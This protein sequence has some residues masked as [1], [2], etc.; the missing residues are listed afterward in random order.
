MGL[1]ID[2]KRANKPKPRGENCAPK[3]R[4]N[5]TVSSYL[6]MRVLGAIESAPGNTIVARIRHVSEP[7]RQAA[8]PRSCSNPSSRCAAAF[9]ARTT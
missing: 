9:A 8:R 2:R 1:L 3:E 6:K 4:E 7:H 5:E